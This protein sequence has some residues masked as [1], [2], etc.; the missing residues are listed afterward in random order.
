MPFDETAHHGGGGGGDGHRSPSD[1]DIRSCASAAA[2]M[3]KWRGVCV[4]C[5]MMQVGIYI[6]ARSL[7]GGADVIA[8]HDDL[9]HGDVDGAVADFVRETMQEIADKYS[10]IMRERIEGRKG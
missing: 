10:E 6:V 7:A 2:L 9:N 4:T 5:T 8:E 3:A 1:E